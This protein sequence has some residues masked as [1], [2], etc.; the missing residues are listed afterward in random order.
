MEA[1]PLRKTE[2]VTVA[3]LTQRRKAIA[4]LRT[5]LF[6]SRAPATQHFGK[7]KLN[8]GAQTGQHHFTGQIKPE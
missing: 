6:P 2:T 7:G 4:S 8:P 5:A 3:E 1:R